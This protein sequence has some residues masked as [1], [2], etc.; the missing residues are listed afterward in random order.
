MFV[1]LVIVHFFSFANFCLVLFVFIFI[2]H[3]VWAL[4][5]PSSRHIFAKFSGPIQ[6]N[7]RGPSTLAQSTLK[8]PRQTKLAWPSSRAPAPAWHLGLHFMLLYRTQLQRPHEPSLL[9]PLLP[10]CFLSSWL[11]SSPSHAK[12]DSMKPLYIAPIPSSRQPA[13]RLHLCTSCTHPVVRGQPQRSASL[14]PQQQPSN[15]NF[16][17]SSILRLHAAAST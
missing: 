3:C 15:P 11:V 6:A 5:C 16:S 13:L 12:I 1:C 10:H 8:L 9:A 4:D 14:S 17:T 2:Y 7:K